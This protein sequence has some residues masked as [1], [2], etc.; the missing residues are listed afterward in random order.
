LLGALLTY[1]RQHAIIETNPVHGI[2]KIADSDVI[3]PGIP[4]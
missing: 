2:R 4:R 1:A 3:R